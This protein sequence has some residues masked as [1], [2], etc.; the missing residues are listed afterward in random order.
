MPD[1]FSLP[2]AEHVVA[3]RAMSWDGAFSRK[4]TPFQEDTLLISWAQR[5]ESLFEQCEARTKVS[6]DL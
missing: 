4:I 1:T 5:N 6:A 2:S 3:L